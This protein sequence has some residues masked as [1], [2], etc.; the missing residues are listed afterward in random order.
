MMNPE[1]YA[2]ID[3]GFDPEAEAEAK[4]AEMDDADD[5]HQLEELEHAQWRGARRRSHTA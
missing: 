3:D 4:H 5:W 1:D 2:D